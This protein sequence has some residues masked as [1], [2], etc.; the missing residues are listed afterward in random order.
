VQTGGVTL[1]RGQPKLGSAARSSPSLR[2]AKAEAAKSAPQ[3]QPQ[4]RTPQRVH[5][6]VASDVIVRHFAAP[7]TRA[8]NAQQ[9]G[10]K[11][12]S[13]MEN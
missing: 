3:I 13:D 9:A 5:E 12:Y 4:H 11:H 8:Q 6:L 10:V 1:Q 2:K 7:A